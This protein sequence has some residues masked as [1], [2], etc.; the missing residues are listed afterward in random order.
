MKVYYNGVTLS[1]VLTKK[2]EETVK[3]DETGIN[4]LGSTITMSF[5]AS[6]LDDRVDNTSPGLRDDVWSDAVPDIIPTGSHGIDSGYPSAQAQISKDKLRRI[7][8]ELQIP[9]RIFRI[10]DDVTDTPIFEAYPNSPNDSNYYNSLSPQQLACVD[11]ANG[12]KPTRVSVDQ[13][14]GGYYRITFEIEINKIRC[15]GGETGEADSNTKYAVADG[16]KLSHRCWT[17]ETIDD[18]FYSTRVTYGKITASS[19][20][21]SRT[22]HHYRPDGYPPLEVGFKRVSVKYSESQDGLSLNYVITDKQVRNSVPY[23]ATSF[24]GTIQYTL[25]NSVQETATLQLTL[26]GNPFVPR[27][28]LLGLAVTTVMNKIDNITGQ[29]GK[30]ELRYNHTIAKYDIVENMGD[31]PSFTITC[32]ILLYVATGEYKSSYRSDPNNVK[33]YT[34]DDDVGVIAN[35]PS[36]NSL[37]CKNFLGKEISESFPSSTSDS[38]KKW[39]YDRKLSA[40]PH[41]YGYNIYGLYESENDNLESISEVNKYKFLKIIASTPCVLRALPPLNGHSSSGALTGKNKTLKQYSVE[42]SNDDIEED[43]KTYVERENYTAI[44]EYQDTGLTKSAL[45]FPYTLYK[46]HAVYSTIYNRSVKPKYFTSFNSDDFDEPVVVDVAPPEGRFIVTIEAERLNSLPE[47]PD[48]EEIL[49]V[50]ARGETEGGISADSATDQDP[51]YTAIETKTTSNTDVENH[52]S[53]KRSAK[54]MK[55]ICLKNDIQIAEPK[56]TINGEGIFYTVLA[57]YEYAISRPIRKGDEI[58]LLLNPLM[59]QQSCYYPRKTI[60]TDGKLQSTP[61]RNNYTVLYNGTVLNHLPPKEN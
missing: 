11:T 49:T 53:G 54:D 1:R 3:Y 56:P 20:N 8:R 14:L 28:V 60:V 27:D 43:L 24:S 16:F 50:H 22:I 30:G 31:P 52:A 42:A 2:W 33:S 37:A 39:T 7:L 61:V 32:V 13:C 29:K 38:Y 10:Y 45:Y 46:S 40:E 55:F 35:S 18:N 51:Y 57:T 26:V 17:E 21:A 23:P 34:F 44:K 47:L 36:V 48:P 9:R 12:P 6:I 58:R 41:P 25:I 4:A 5:E 59:T 15:L 19:T